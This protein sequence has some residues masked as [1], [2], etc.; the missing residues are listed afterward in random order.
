MKTIN[1][2]LL[3]TLLLI[4]AVAQADGPWSPEPQRQAEL[5]H[6]LRQDCGA[7]HGMRLLGG[8]G[9]ALTPQSLNAKPREFL[10]TTILEGRAGTPMPPWKPFLTRDEATWLATRLKQG[11]PE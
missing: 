3:A 4:S 5:I 8:L 2:M 9:P 7:C 6:L 11:I 10:V 1:R